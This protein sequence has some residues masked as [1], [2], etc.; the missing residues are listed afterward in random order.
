M[1]SQLVT[2]SQQANTLYLLAVTWTL[3]S[4]PP[5]PTLH[6]YTI[7]P[8]HH[9]TITPLH[10][11]TT[12]PLHHYTTPPSANNNFRTTNSFKKQY[13]MAKKNHP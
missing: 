1:Q 2:L 4:S 8:L 10:H 6:H 11:Y 9:Y 5:N 13:E 3:H 7:T 12:T